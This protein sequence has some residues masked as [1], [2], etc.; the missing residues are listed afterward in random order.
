MAGGREL[1][2]G[3]GR[4]SDLKLATHS[5]DYGG[6]A[7]RVPTIT[8]R[9]KR[10]HPVSNLFLRTLDTAKPLCHTFFNPMET[11]QLRRS[12][13][14]KPRV[15]VLTRP[16]TRSSAR[17]NETAASP[18]ASNGADRGADLF[19]LFVGQGEA[20]MGIVVDRE[21]RGHRLGREDCPPAEKEP[22]PRV[23]EISVSVFCLDVARHGVLR[24]AHVESRQ[25]REALGG[26]ANLY[27]EVAL[28]KR[29]CP[30]RTETHRG[31]ASAYVPLKRL[32]I[33]I[34]NCSGLRGR[35]AEAILTAMEEQLRARFRVNGASF[36]PRAVGLG[37]FTEIS[38]FDPK[39]SKY[40]LT[41]Y[42]FDTV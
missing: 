33:E 34:G 36:V 16:T 10:L 18:V 15:L 8:V 22:Y 23:Q 6:K 25:V 14:V 4:R 30:L 38:P 5:V 32:L 37:P 13:S 9:K 2:S 27:L 1:V 26:I 19:T 28:S 42:D 3:A 20:D 7:I 12:T 35:L 21:P 41:F 11:H 40:R 31:F 24:D 29:L 17:K 39:E